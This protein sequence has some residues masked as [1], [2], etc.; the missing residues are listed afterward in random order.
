MEPPG[1]QVVEAFTQAVLVA[2][3]FA[4][5]ALAYAAI[6]DAARQQ[7]EATRAQR[8]QAQQERRVALA[9]ARRQGHPVPRQR[10]WRAPHAL[11]PHWKIIPAHYV[12]RG[13][14]CCHPATAFEWRAPDAVVD[15]HYHCPHCH[16]TAFVIKDQ[17]EPGYAEAAYVSVFFATERLDPEH[18]AWIACRT[19]EAR[20]PLRPPP[21]TG[22]YHWAKR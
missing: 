2:G 22:P 20:V 8:R 7:R 16:G 10:P 13:C 19:C 4:S 1:Y 18:Y 21:P 14:D 12:W 5:E 6:V 3:P 11:S 15:I 17:P 9:Q